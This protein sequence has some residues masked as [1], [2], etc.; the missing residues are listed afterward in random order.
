MGG[1]VT[2]LW[3][4]RELTWALFQR[5][6]KS[7][8][9]QSLLGYVWLVVPP[10]VTAAGWYAMNRSGLMQLSTGS[11]PPAQFIVVGTTLWSAFAASL[12]IPMDSF[13]AGQPVFTKLNVPI[14]AFILAGLGR[15]AFNLLI[16]SATLF[17]LLLLIGVRPGPTVLL[18]PAAACG[19]L[20]MGF[21][22]GLV[23]VPLNALYADVR[24]VVSA[25]TGLLMF[26]VPVIFQVPEEGSGVIAAVIRHNPL[27]PAF[28]L[29]RETLLT[30]QLD[31]LVP[32]ACWLLV[33]IPV[34]VVTLVVLR[35][36]RPHLVARMGM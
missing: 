10:I 25:F 12:T 13:S 23:F 5:D 24:Q 31:W 29:S 28:A 19:V 35:V 9:R 7:Q 18:F 1:I 30:G 32:A 11:S 6:L 21:T 17:L 14:E 26:T 2:D 27:T 8:F 15:A 34:N 4:C 3:R 33:C 36:S 22:A 20:A 16:S